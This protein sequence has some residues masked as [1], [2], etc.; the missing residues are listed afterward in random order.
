MH[1][2]PK[3]APLRGFESEIFKLVSYGA[4]P[5]QWAQWLRV[6]LEHAAGRGNLDLVNALIEAGADGS[7][8]WRGCRGRTL[9]DAAA[10]GG[11]AGVITAL[12]RAGARPDL[13]AVTMSPKRSALYV[14]TVCGHLEAARSLII[15]GADVNFEDPRDQRCVL[16]EAVL[17]GHQQLVNEL[18]IAR[19]NPNL[20]SK[21]RFGATALHVAAVGGHVEIVSNLLLLAG[22]DKD[23]CDS[24]GDSA[25][26]WAVDSGHLAVVETLLKAGV[27]TT[28]RW[29]A[30]GRFSALH[31]A[32]FPGRVSI[33]KAI[34]AHGEDV[35]TY[36]DNGRTALHCAAEY[37]HVG[38]IDVLIEAGADVD[39]EAKD[40]GWTPLFHAALFHNREAMLALLRHGADINAL[41][42]DDDNEQDTVLHQ[43]CR[44]QDP[45]LELV[46][47]LLLRW[48]ADETYLDTNDKTPAMNLDFLPSHPTCPPAEI[49]R[50][51]LLL[52]RAPADRAWR[53]RCW[54]IMLHSRSTKAGA[55]G[56]EIG[57]ETG[58]SSNQA[59]GR[60]GQSLKNAK[61]E[62]QPFSI[63]CIA[64]AKGA[65]L[66]GVVKF[67]VD[68][69]VQDVFR[70]V[71]GFL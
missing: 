7:A 71:V 4:S 33:L 13:D 19:A 10:V 52:A 61:T 14:A 64:G 40:D 37:N 54:L 20:A 32:V 17:G 70:T 47:D 58:G 6:P 46:V 30:N 36:D 23:A 31:R 29:S 57:G 16:H 24:R 68:R 53:R 12:L 8:G 39:V 43:V 60:A 21:G 35:D 67:L 1:L 15:A 11:S 22:I 5:E 42:S 28:S 48:G 27:R 2:F 59:G 49:E 63:G 26:I 51:R 65:G 62:G 44:R 55:H 69:G 38:A 45:G 34:L 9:L 18:L 66:S 3:R 25:L 41:P 50:V 56:Y